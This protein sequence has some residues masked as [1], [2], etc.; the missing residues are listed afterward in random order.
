MMFTSYQDVPLLIDFWSKRH[1][2]SNTSINLLFLASVTIVQLEP[3]QTPVRGPAEIAVP[4]GDT[5]LILHNSNINQK[6]PGFPKMKFQVNCTEER[7]QEW[8]ISSLVDRM[9]TRTEESQWHEA[10]HPHSR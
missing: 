2:V 8:V 5:S 7:K 6:D 9:F 1:T 10:P 4:R 3:C